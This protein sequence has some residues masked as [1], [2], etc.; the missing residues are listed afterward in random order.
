MLDLVQLLYYCDCLKEKRT[1]ALQEQDVL[2]A[3]CLEKEAVVHGRRLD[4][5]ETLLAAGPDVVE[6]QGPCVQIAVV[7]GV[8]GA[9]GMDAAPASFYSHTYIFFRGL[10]NAGLSDRFMV[11]SVVFQFLSHWYRRPKL[12]SP[13]A[14]QAARW[15]EAH[16]R[17]N[18]TAGRLSEVLGYSP[19]HIMHCFSQAYG[20]PVHTYLMRCRMA[21]VKEEITKNEKSMEEIALESGFSCRSALHKTF[22]RLYGIT[23][24]QYRRYIERNERE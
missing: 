20:M 6:V 24:G 2:V 12:E 17:E 16:Y 13:V 21:H 5:Q 18:V 7:R 23:P 19:W 11:S 14:V 9:Q 15:I 4:V 3:V 1:F 8:P 22:V 10:E